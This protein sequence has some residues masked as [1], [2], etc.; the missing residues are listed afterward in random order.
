MEPL[1]GRILD[2][3]EGLIL[4]NPKDKD[5][6]KNVQS[7]EI[8]GNLYGWVEMYEPDTITDLQRDHF[9]ALV[10]DISEY[11]GFPMDVVEANMKY[12][13]MNRVHLDEFP[14]VK[15]NAMKKSTASQLIE[16]CIDYCIKYEIPFRKQQ[17]YLTADTSKM[18]FALT[19]KRM[20]VVC[21]KPHSDMHHATNLVGMGNK[22]SR[23]NNLLS[24]FLCLCR[25]HHNIIHN[26]GLTAF[27]EKYYVK[28]VRL[29][30][31]QL[32]EIGVS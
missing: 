9:F 14:S 16:F 28:P 25:E 27:C 15:R 19:M 2:V 18:I 1:K 20:C 26:I 21:G 32:K 7:Y 8:N 12:G 30:Q 10:K 3:S 4:F 24:T 22:R 31:Q 23:H 11:E 17:F 13:F 6:L 5:L 29:N